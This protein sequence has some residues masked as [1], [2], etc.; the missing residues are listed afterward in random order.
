M[1]NAMKMQKQRGFTLVELMIVITIIGILA[2]IGYPA[3]TDYATRGRVAE[4]TGGLVNWKNKMTQFYMDTR[5]YDGSLGCC[6]PPAPVS[7]YFDFSIP[8]STPTSYTM[9]AQ[10]KG[11]MLGFTYTL[12]QGNGRTSNTPWGSSPTCWVT[13]RGD[14]TCP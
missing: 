8:S 14:T 2:G 1:E 3:Y 5:A 11:A 13:K 12:D 4:A 6:Q 9:V 7:T 10:G